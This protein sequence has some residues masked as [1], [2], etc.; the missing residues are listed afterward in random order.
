M[1]G[2]QQALRAGAGAV[3]RIAVEG[4]GPETLRER[5]RLRPPRYGSAI[6]PGRDLLDEL[7]EKIVGG[8]AKDGVGRDY[9]G[10]AAE[11]VRTHP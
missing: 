3:R 2:P 6:A 4:G 11:A 7:L 9:D 1:Q 5:T 10:G 8:L